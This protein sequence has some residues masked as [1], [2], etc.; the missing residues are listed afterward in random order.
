MAGVYMQDQFFAPAFN[1]RSYDLKSYPPSTTRHVDE[2]QHD[3]KDHGK[4]F[5]CDPSG[6]PRLPPA[7]AMADKGNADS[8]PRL[9]VDT[10]PPQIPRGLLIPVQPPTLR[11]L[12]NSVFRLFDSGVCCY[13]GCYVTH[14]RVSHRIFDL[15]SYAQFIYLF[16]FLPYTSCLCSLF[17]IADISGLENPIPLS[18]Q[19]LL[20][21]PGENK[22]G[23]MSMD[24]HFSSCYGN[25]TDAIKSLGDGEDFHDADKRSIV[26]RPSFHDAETGHNNRW[27][28]EEREMNF[29]VRKD[30]WRDGDKDKE[31]ADS[32]WER[33]TEHSSRHSGEVRRASAD[34][35]ND[36]VNRETNFEQRRESKWNTRWGPDDKES[37]GWREKRMDSGR[38]GEGSRDKG[39]PH[40]LNP[41]KDVEKEGG[42]YSRP[43]R[44]N[45]LARGRGDSPLTHVKQGQT[46]IYGRGRGENGSPFFS[47]GRGKSNSIMVSSDSSA[48]HSQFLGSLPEKPVGVHGD[49][50]A[51]RYSR[52]KLLDIYRVVNVK[53]DRKKLDDFIEVPSLTQVEPLEPLAISAPSPEELVVFKGIDK[54]DI[55][56][57][58]IP[59]ATKDVL[60]GRAPADAV[61]PRHG[62][63]EDSSSAM[64][65]SKDDTSEKPKDEHHSYLD[66]ASYEGYMHQRGPNLKVESHGD[67][68]L[69]IKASR[70][71]GT[72]LWKTD[73]AAVREVSTLDESSS[74]RHTIPWRADSGG[75]K[76]PVLSKDWK[77]LSANARSR[78]SDVSWLHLQKDQD[79][80]WMSTDAVSSSS[81]GHKMHWQNNQGFQ[82]EM[83]KDLRFK[84]QSSE[85]LDRD[86]ETDKMLGHDDSFISGDKTSARK[87]QQQPSPEELLLY[88]R[89]PQGQ[90]QG[91]FSGSDLIGWFEA[92][93]FGI[94][95]QV[96]LVDAPPDSPF[97]LLG[98]V[99]P[100]LRMKAKPPPG[101]SVHKQIE[102]VDASVRGKLISP[103]NTHVG[104]EYI[105][106]GQKN[107]HDSS[108]EAHN[109]LLESLMYGNMSNSAD[110]FS[111]PEGVKGYVS[112]T[113]IA[114]STVGVDPGYSLSYPLAQR[115]TLEQQGSL[116]NHL[117]F[118]TGKDPAS[119]SST[120]DFVLNSP[121]QHSKL[122][123]AMADIPLSVSQ[124]SQHVDLL[125]ILQTA[126]EK[127]PS[128]PV[129]TN[130]PTLSNFPDA[131]LLDKTMH[132]SIDIQSQ[133]GYG[134][135][136]QR[137]QQLN[138]PTLSPMIPQP[139]DHLANFV[140]PEKVPS[141]GISQD[142]NLLSM[143]QHQ[144]LLS[145]LPLQS[146]MPLPTQL[147]LLDK[148]ILM[149]EHQ[150]QEQ[151]QLLLQQQ[152]LLSR[153]L[154]EH[155]SQQQFGE[156]PYGHLQATG[157]IGNVLSAHSGFHQPVETVQINEQMEALNV[158]DRRASNLSNLPIQ[159]SKDLGCVIGSSQSALLTPHEFFDQTAHAKEWR[160][161]RQELESIPSSNS[162][163]VVLAADNS[164]P[165]G[166]MEKSD[167]SL[168]PGFLQNS[169]QEPLSH[170]N[171]ALDVE[172][173][174]SHQGGET[175]ELIASKERASFV[176]LDGS[177]ETSKDASTSEQ[178][179]D[180]PEQVNDMKCAPENISEQ[181]TSQTLPVKNA[182]PVEGSGVKKA[183]EKKSRKQKN[184]KT[185]ST[186][187]QS[188][189]SSKLVHSQQL[190]LDPETEGTST[191]GI[192]LV[193]QTEEKET[194]H[195]TP[196]L[197]VTDGKSVIVNVEAPSSQGKYIVGGEG[198]ASVNKFELRE[199]ERASQS[200]MQT[201]VQRAWKPA[202]APRAKSLLEIQQEEQERAQ[203]QTFA[204]DVVASSAAASGFSTPW[205]GVVACSDH[206][207]GREVLQGGTNA[208][209]SLSS[210]ADELNLTC[211]KSQLHD[212][213]PE[214]VIAKSTEDIVDTSTTVN[215]SSILS[216]PANAK[217]QTDG[218]P[219]ADDDFVDA[220]D[221]KKSRKKAAKA[222]GAGV[223]SSVPVTL[224]D[225]IS[226]IP[227]RQAQKEELPSAIPNGPSLGDFV[228]WKG[229]QINSAPGPAWSTDSLRAQ[230]P[231][232]LRD[233]LKEQE[234]NTTSV[235]KP[236][237]VV[238]SSK[239]QQ[240]RN[241]HGSSSWQTSGTSPIKNS[242]RPN[243]TK[244]NA[245]EE[246]FW[247][248]LDQ[249]KQES[250]LYVLNI[251]LQL[252]RS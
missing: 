30:R 215:R 146:Q 226:S 153:I 243:M 9:A 73:D 222:K 231:T 93:Y 167:S 198:E 115:V 246:L 230:K 69:T 228:F 139:S 59:Q 210:S 211:K 120:Q 130:L 78:T 173:S 236:I 110:I 92:G 212:L 49:S 179:N 182:N 65:S 241:V 24:S 6:A 171:S 116:P 70:S 4:G 119:M 83:S 45:S 95:L 55:V 165:D 175:A 72:N 233:I 250:K 166:V 127:A 102:T 252:I 162:A 16:S 52:M 199:G 227:V 205:A 131:R 23:M 191:G 43:W 18:P 133:S 155:Q 207:S 125:S 41:G 136:S 28:D 190:K 209:L 138:Q 244:S 80:K 225:P 217:T 33:W 156:S 189:G 77:D 68:I 206:K 14:I 109:R 76:S 97:S 42:H 86:R 248:P 25:H 219:F 220:K 176:P 137:L 27:H 224:A 183:S 2:Q 39:T 186:S 22:S 143:L 214:E 63:S 11:C 60:V 94:D 172:I 197:R 164:L 129:N 62:S 89:D 193:S 113:S 15:N 159:V 67:G 201:P 103:G 35:W 160:S 88:Y 249:P 54:G 13:Y 204:S 99:V 26:S 163:P 96:R 79:A 145:Q 178:G 81:Y 29:A 184:V 58:G 100:H 57:S 66:G 142:P 124:V 5:P 239:T 128:P 202:P 240:N 12:L 40:Q 121:P 36:S 114:M 118:W 235:P 200:T 126:A 151:Q 10:P 17:G 123:P 47:A 74:F 213:M 101:F 150:K 104:F 7:P 75:E 34:R 157:S 232:S 53:N 141:S 71:E 185:Q 32:R 218:P 44:P 20:P 122:I 238:G 56:S 135:P 195:G 50:S 37:D 90:I 221:M 203:I 234:K 168:Q 3:E 188:K 154:S 108:T 208:Q 64:Y 21:K 149:K 82:S 180:I 147:S 106:N 19:W 112:G 174:M 216:P 177:S 134:I 46:F 132:S 51:L 98:D 251:A 8:R 196:A 223:K 170:E 187:E 91:P 229:D 31:T 194:P 192:T 38:D 242:L 61:I 48:S 148:F 181:S 87:F 84:R 140:L 152:H 158:Q 1:P 85:V 245:D 161:S 237:P 169:S 111:F 117:P 144:Y 105:N 107:R 247:G